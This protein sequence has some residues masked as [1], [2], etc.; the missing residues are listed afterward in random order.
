MSNKGI[1]NET[2]DMNRPMCQCCTS[3]IINISSN[4]ALDSELL[5]SL[6]I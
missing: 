2:P 5:N 1:V 6:Q 3:Y 4:Q